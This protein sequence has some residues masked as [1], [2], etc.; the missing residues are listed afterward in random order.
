MKTAPRLLLVDDDEALR[1][2]L[3]RALA[4]AG[5]VTLEAA[6]G[7]AALRV[8]TAT[9]VDLVITDI[10]MPEMEGIDVIIS[11][12]KTHPTLPVIAM[13]GGGR[14]RPDEYLPIARALGAAR[15]LAKPFEIAQLLDL[16][17]ELVGTPP[18]DGA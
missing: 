12:R 18:T 8:L 15:V 4:R 7:L 13:S 2:V 1:L 11:A 14:S 16:V 3:C 10:V 5:Y 17:R 6:D 9:P